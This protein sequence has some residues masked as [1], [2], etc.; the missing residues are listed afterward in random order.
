M[1]G[2]AIGHYDVIA[3]LGEGGMGAVYKA[4]DRK[5]DRFVAL[6]TI[7]AAHV[8]DQS[9]RR[10]FIQEAKAASAL[11]H[12][13]IITVYEIADWEGA[14]FIAMEFIEGRTLGSLAEA[15][16]DVPTLLPIFRQVAEAV[17]V[18]HAAGIVHRD[19]KP[20]NVM[21]RPDGYVKVLDFG[22]ARLARRAAESPDDTAT[23]PGMVLGTAR[24]M[25]PEQARGEAAEAPSDV[26]SLGVVFYELATGTHPFSAVTAGSTIWAIL[27]Q[28][29]SPPSRT[30]PEVPTVLDDLILRMVAKE[31]V[32]RPTAATVLS[33]LTALVQGAPA[34]P[35]ARALPARRTCVGRDRELKELHGA[36]A[37]AAAGTGTLVCVT[38]EPGLGKSALVEEFLEGLRSQKGSA[39]L[40]RGRCSERLGG[41]D[42]LLP[43][44]EALDSLVRGDSGDQVARAMS[45]FAPNWYLQVAPVMG[46]VTKEA[47]V[48]Q[49]KTASQERIKR[50][51]HAFL[52]ELSRTRPVVL[53][54]DDVHWS[55]ASTCDLVSYVESRCRDLPVLVVVTYRP[56]ELLAGRHLFQQVRLQWEARGSARDVGLEFL[57]RPDVE[58]LVALRFPDHHFPA[59]LLDLVHGKTEGNPLFISDMLRYLRDSSVLRQEDGVW[60]M[61]RPVAEIE[62]EV[63]ASIRSMIQLKIE[64]F[65]DED[66]RLLTAAAVQGVQFDSAVLARALAQDPADV[67]ERLQA[68][69]TL[70][71][72]VRS[73]GEQEFP[74][75]TLTVRYRFVHVF[76]QNALYSALTPSRRAALSRTIADAVLAFGGEKLPGLAADLAFLFESARDFGRAAPFFLAA[77]RHAARL[78][79]HPEAAILAQKG[80]RS[81]EALPDTD[82]RARLELTLSVTLG[83]ALMATRGYAAPDVERT[84]LRSREL[85]LRLGDS[86]RLLPVLWALFVVYLIGGRLKRAL[87]V[88]EEMQG[89]AEASPD[90]A[91]RIEALHAMGVALGYM[92]RFGEARERLQRILDACDP[93]EHPYHASVYVL[94]PIITSLCMMGRFRVL[95][96]DSEEAVRCADVAVERARRIVHPQSLAYATF[97]QAWIRHDLGEVEPVLRLAE[98]AIAQSEEHGLPQIREWARIARGWALCTMGRLREGVDEVRRSLSLQER[99]HSALERPYCL[100]LL[101]RGLA[102]QG[103]HDEALERLDEA[104]ALVEA[105]GERLYEA[106]IHRLRGDVLLARV[107]E[108]EATAGPGDGGLA[109]PRTEDPLLCRAQEEYEKAVEVA[110]RSGARM[111]ELRAAASLFR[112]RQRLGDPGAARALLE[113]AA[114]PFDGRTGV[115]YLAEA[116]RLLA[117]EE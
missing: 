46:N 117:S 73:V 24:Y 106:E 37:A 77:A 31:P 14:D 34:V 58:R 79:A 28:N 113:D 4:R 97:W 65:S 3:K 74:D 94:D 114:A 48:E 13:N 56:S 43:V 52:E 17:A 27:S 92:G 76:Y 32:L 57:T 47:L 103:Q 81:L 33:E 116:Q 25:S 108:D 112:L 42:A 26:F 86:R 23:S 107:L 19:L 91:N 70:H 35:L 44:L 66:R 6:K 115:P 10:R 7:A 2:R 85:C 67:E 29:P 72:F 82:Q 99:M 41:T 22:L 102:L 12:P 88:A 1:D 16:P 54:L 51:M 59:E 50:E 11:N 110:R 93:R 69:D 71:G 68:L 36:Y 83:V 109:R 15:P 63:P 5:L 89:P 49:A 55:D 20:D 9:R 105:N 80:L 84:H 8:S 111:H 61:A 95:V 60:V 40:A 104:L 64:R 18:A 30:N 96:G 21:L 100:G 39:W 98:S 38:G 78:F 53:F 87:E 62:K 45:R 75:R 90:P 101:A